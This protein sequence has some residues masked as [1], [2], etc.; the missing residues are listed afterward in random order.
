MPIL[1][2][3]LK[4]IALAAISSPKKTIDI[5]NFFVDLA[6]KKKRKP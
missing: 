3:A 5:L 4:S 2:A 1:I 6:K